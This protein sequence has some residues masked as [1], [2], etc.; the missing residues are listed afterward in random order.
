MD[1]I[2][3]VHAVCSATAIVGVTVYFQYR[4][5]KINTELSEQKEKLSSI[6]NHVKAQDY[7]IRQMMDAL[8]G[9]E[10]FTS[11]HR[12]RKL[13]N[14]ATVPSPKRRVKFK[15][16]NEEDT[17]RQMREDMG[18]DEEDEDDDI[19]PELEDLDR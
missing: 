10:A 4:L 5:T 18:V 19:S 8:G 9:P 14:P 16:E 15:D 1:R 2:Q 3:I 17:A 11:G 13:S 7:A 12:N 6:E